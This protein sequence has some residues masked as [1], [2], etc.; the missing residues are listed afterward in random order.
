MLP[1]KSPEDI[2]KLPTLREVIIHLAGVT[3]DFDL[4]GG[5]LSREHA[6]PPDLKWNIPMVDYYNQAEN[7]D[8]IVVQTQRG[9]HTLKPNLRSRPFLF[10]GQNT[11][12]GSIISSFTQ[13]EFR[14]GKRVQNRVENR[15]KHL[16]ANLKAEDF[17]A[18]LKTHPLFMML[19]RGVVLAPETKPIFINMN[20]YGLAQHYNFRTGL[21][22]FTTDIDVACFFACT[23]NKGND[24]YECITD[25]SRYGV[26]YVHKIEPSMTFKA[27][28]FTTIG[29]QLYPRSGA[30][31]GVCFN[32]H[33]TMFDVNKLVQPV[34]FRHDA[35]VS[36]HIFEVM[37]GGKK[38]FPSDSISKYAKIILDG[39]E[40]TGATF[41]NNLYSNCDDYNENLR[42]LKRNNIKVNWHKVMHFTS[43]MLND[44]KL[45]LKNGLWEQF[46]SQIYFAD[47]KKGKQMHESL[48]NLPRNPAY[49]HY[50]DVKEYSRIIAYDDA[51]HQ[52]AARN[53]QL[54][55]LRKDSS[56]NF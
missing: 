41:A 46:C 25:S 10:R 48:L 35:D 4:G 1:P 15:E 38:L 42:V 21:I 39:N 18:L 30:Q 19:D 14:N 56:H 29:L 40:V 34:Y 54:L 16:I 9:R 32:E 44:L 8:F 33:E 6:F 47:H 7:E 45:D 37:D 53:A 11:D 12:Y 31:K 28:G 5:W 51:L 36:Q 52:R 2:K 13:Q 22:D 3:D 27:Y 17:M 49:Q 50:F 26:L 24:K 20:Y 55:Q 43:E 23:C